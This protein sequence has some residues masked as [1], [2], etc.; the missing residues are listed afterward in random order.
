MVAPTKRSIARIYSSCRIQW[1]GIT[2]SCFKLC[3]RWLYSLTVI[4]FARLSFWYS[5]ELR[6]LQ[7]DSFTSSISEIETDLSRTSD[8]FWEAILGNQQL[9]N[10]EGLN[11]EE[12]LTLAGMFR[13]PAWRLYLEVLLSY[14]AE[15]ARQLET[16]ARDQEFY[17]L[18]GR[19]EQLR[20]QAIMPYEIDKLIQ[21][22][23]LAEHQRML[24]K[25]RETRRK[26]R[27][28]D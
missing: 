26:E 18:Q 15:I 19:A 12:C 20:L 10:R 8:K 2:S 3:R 28:L 17:R 27:R 13:S 22:F 9:R 24:E 21:A 6:I 25:E 5:T 1:L 4:P 16:V 11:K 14:R 23:K 7:I